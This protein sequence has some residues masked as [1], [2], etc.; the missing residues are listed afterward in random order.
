M[1]FPTTRVRSTES[2]GHVHES[3]VK[4]VSLEANKPF[5]PRNI[6]ESKILSI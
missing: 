4:R 5:G 1:L 3:G 6:P 2:R